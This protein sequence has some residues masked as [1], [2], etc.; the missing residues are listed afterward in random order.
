MRSYAVTRQSV[1]HYDKWFVFAVIC[2]VALGLLMMTSASIVISD[3]QMHQPFYFLF[4]QLIFLTLGVLLG[5][6]VMQIDTSTW[7][8][9]GMYLLLSVMLLLA[10]VL[11]PGIGN[12]ANGSARWI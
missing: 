3:R 9:W 1:A 4:K 10:L 8:K 5:S 11:I 12:S 6:L 2:I 7:E